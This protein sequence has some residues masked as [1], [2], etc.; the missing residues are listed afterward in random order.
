MASYKEIF[1]LRMSEFFNYKRTENIKATNA[2]RTN[3]K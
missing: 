2:K 3:Q 1:T